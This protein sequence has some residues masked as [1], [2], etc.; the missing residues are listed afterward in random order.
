[1]VGD[2]SSVSAENSSGSFAQF[3]AEKRITKEDKSRR[4]RDE[5]FMTAGFCNDYAEKEPSF[6]RN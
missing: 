3:T 6:G 5:A 4:A 1:M 2:P